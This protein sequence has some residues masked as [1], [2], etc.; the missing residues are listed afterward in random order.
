VIA[1]RVAWKRHA[2]HGST[3]RIAWLLILALGC[4]HRANASPDAE[5]TGCD[6]DQ[7]CALTRVEPGGCCPMLCEPRV[8][9]RK[10]AVALEANVDTCNKGKPCALPLCRPPA[11]TITPVCVQN[12]CVARTGPSN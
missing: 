2:K 9:T 4:A 12:R 10:R 6:T 3:M 11:Q 5:V 7:D 8:V 1:D